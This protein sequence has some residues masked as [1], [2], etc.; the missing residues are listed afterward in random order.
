MLEWWLQKF[1][2]KNTDPTFDDF[3]I[4]YIPYL[5][6]LIVCYKFCWTIFTANFQYSQLQ[7]W[8]STTF[9]NLCL[10]FQNLANVI[11]LKIN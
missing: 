10:T 7:I 3:W 6:D 9:S 11:S 5:S 8:S 2:S 1:L 4:R